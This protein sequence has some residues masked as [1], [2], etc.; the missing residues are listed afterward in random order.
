VVLRASGFMQNFLPPHPVGAGIRLRGEIRT[1]AGDGRVGWIDVQDVAE[2][3]AALLSDADFDA[4]GDYQLTGPGALSY[5]EAASIIAAESGRPVRVRHLEADDLAAGHRAAGL[6]PSFAA[7]LAAAENGT[8][9]GDDAQIT[10]AVFDLTGRAP[11]SFDEFVRRHKSEW[12][13]AADLRDEG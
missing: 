12:L 9:A 10:T 13:D 5:P 8:K 3:A 7:S 2:S 4:A 1:A 6:P 11:R